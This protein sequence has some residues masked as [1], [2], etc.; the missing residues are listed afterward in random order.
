M[1]H[2]HE[3]IEDMEKN[4]G[5]EK[6]IYKGVADVTP[7][8]TSSESATNE[9]EMFESKPGAELEELVIEEEES[10]DDSTRSVD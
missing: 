10:G 8:Q 5:G 2:E 4:V 9:V 6:L 3:I 1:F 7:R